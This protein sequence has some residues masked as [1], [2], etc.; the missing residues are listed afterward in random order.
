MLR[1]PNKYARPSSAELVHSSLPPDAGGVA[2][3]E[4]S[5]A[6]QTA[7]PVIMPQPVEPS[8]RLEGRHKSIRTI[9]AEAFRLC[10]QLLMSPLTGK[11]TSRTVLALL[12][13]RPVVRT[14]RQQQP[15]AETCLCEGGAH[16]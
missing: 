15:G 10:G 5:A 7:S 14:V 1:Q 6:C 8:N 13:H 9:C 3:P 2:A 12:L 4:G 16:A 11:D